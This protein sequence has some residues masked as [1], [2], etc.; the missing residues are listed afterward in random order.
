MRFSHIL[1]QCVRNNQLVDGLQ[2]SKLDNANSLNLQEEPDRMSTWLAEELLL[3]VTV[4]SRATQPV[5][6]GQL[7]EPP[8]FQSGALQCAQ[9]AAT[10]GVERRWRPIC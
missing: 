5:V 2:G 3:W 4:A 10:R 9:P 6:S 1:E 8:T 7:V